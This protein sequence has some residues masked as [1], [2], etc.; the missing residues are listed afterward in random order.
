MQL[1]VGDLVIFNPD[2]RRIFA[3]LASK[4]DEE[5]QLYSGKLA[6]VLLCCDE[7]KYCV[8]TFGSNSRK[9]AVSYSLLRLVSRPISVHEVVENWFEIYA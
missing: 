7:R 2:N 4:C 1:K 8:I 5:L 6:H 9:E 3:P